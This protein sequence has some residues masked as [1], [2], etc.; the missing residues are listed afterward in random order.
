MSKKGTQQLTEIN[1]GNITKCVITSTVSGKAFDM[2]AGVVELNYYE[3]VLSNTITA[4]LIIVDTGY[5]AGGTRQAAGGTRKSLVDGLPI[6]GGERVDLEFTDAG[7]PQNKI[8]LPLYVNRLKA[9]DSKTQRDVF[10]LD[11]VTKEYLSN[12]LTRVTKRYQGRISENI[13]SILSDVLK[14][15]NDIHADATAI[16]YNFFG[17]DR[18]PFYVC[19]WLASKSTPQT[20]GT[21]G[22]SVGGTAGFLFYQTNKGFNFKSLDGLL[23]QTPDK[24]FVYTGT[25]MAGKDKR[26]ILTYNIDRNIELQSNLSVGVYNNRTI[27]YDP[28][29]FNYVVVNFNL[30]KQQDK[31]S[32]AG[33]NFS[34]ELVDKA[35]TSGPSRL[36]SNVMDVGYNPT[37]AT[38]EEQLQNWKSQPR[39]SN[40]D[41]P[42]TMVQS[43]M[44]YNQVFTIQTNITIG[45]DFSL[46]AGDMINCTF[47]QTEGESRDEINK[48][49]EGN[50]LIAHL[51][52]RITPEKTFTS[53][54][55]VRDSYGKPEA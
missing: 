6:R 45:G 30:S 44:R 49:T 2:R 37:G 47:K 50:Y 19:T 46:S 36:M 38:P 14:T 25:P 15:D 12:E 52:H 39:Q 4:S 17:N 21:S 54:G 9:T 51:C 24:K 35:F 16:D 31:I 11:L 42:R 20:A 41:A 43:V 5:S 55:L 18:K 34:A 48:Q 32:T 33:V 13:K 3:S 1:A 40:F 10:I 23:S 53:L 8:S 7:N 28:V 29:A 26:N 27:F 22:S